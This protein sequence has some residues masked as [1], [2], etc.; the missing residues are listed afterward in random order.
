MHL[1]HGLPVSQGEVIGA[2]NNFSSPSDIV[3]CAAGSLPGDLHKLWRTA[4]RKG[5][6]LGVWLFLYGL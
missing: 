6:H 3:L 2:V 1:N 5:F 4:D